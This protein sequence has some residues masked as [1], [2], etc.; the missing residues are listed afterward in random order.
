FFEQKL[1]VANQLSW[2]RRVGVEFRMSAPE[3]IA[4]NNAHYFT[5]LDVIGLLPYSLPGVPFAL[6]HG[7]VSHEHFHAHFQHEVMHALAQFAV[8]PLDSLFCFEALGVKPTRPRP[9]SDPHSVP[10]LNSVV[11]RAWNEGLADLF[12]T[13]YTGRSDFFVASFPEENQDRDL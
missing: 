1:G 12:A 5:Q 11:L 2:P 6:N 8:S 3:G 10:S 13:V 9:D 4:Q 7:I